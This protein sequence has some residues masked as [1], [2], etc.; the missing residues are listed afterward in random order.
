[1]QIQSQHIITFCATALFLGLSGCYA[2]RG[3][4]IDL[5]ER[6]LSQEIE[7]ACWRQDANALAHLKQRAGKARELA[8]EKTC[9]QETAHSR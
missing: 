9:D 3:H 1:M 6:E 4:P 5:S 8:Q 7:R 2:H